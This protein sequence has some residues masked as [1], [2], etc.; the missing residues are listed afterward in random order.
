MS[1][2]VAPFSARARPGAPVSMPVTWAQVNARLDPGKYTIRTVPG[3]LARSKAWA[4][5]CDSL[6]PLAPAIQA[7]LKASR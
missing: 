2:A 3:L 4:E 7:L 1:T 5:Y 6:R